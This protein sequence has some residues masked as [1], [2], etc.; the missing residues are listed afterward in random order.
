MEHA[1]SDLGSKEDPAAAA[2]RGIPCQP[3]D[4]EQVHGRDGYLPDLSQSEPVEAELQGS[5]RALSASEL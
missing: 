5:H 3:E 4:G 1:E 2:D